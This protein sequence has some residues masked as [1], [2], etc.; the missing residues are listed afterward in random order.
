[1]WTKR[2]FVAVVALLLCGTALSSGAGRAEA[3]PIGD[4]VRAVDAV[5]PALSKRLGL[6]DSQIQPVL[7]AQAS[8]L[9]PVND[10]AQ[11]RSFQREWENFTPRQ[12]ARNEVTK[13]VDETPLP[14]KIAKSIA[15]ETAVDLAFRVEDV[16]SWKYAVD[17]LNGQ[18]QGSYPMGARL[19]IYNDVNAISQSLQRG[20]ICEAVAKLAVLVAKTKYCG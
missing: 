10:A 16:S 11:L 6:L 5:V 17:Q 7:V 9:T 2:L 1:M 20:C 15:C 13:V 12:P 4:I 18:V 14:M 19:A 3:V 8:K